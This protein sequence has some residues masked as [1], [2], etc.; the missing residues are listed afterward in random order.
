MTNC[1]DSNTSKTSQLR[2][3]RKQQAQLFTQNDADG[4]QQRQKR[5]QW[6]VTKAMAALINR[7]FRWP[8]ATQPTDTAING[9][10][11]WD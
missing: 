9:Q 8:A 2:D 6:Q 10:D 3:H 4:L 1:N 7:V 5:K 11:C